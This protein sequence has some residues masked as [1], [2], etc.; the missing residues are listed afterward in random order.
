MKLKVITFW[1]LLLGPSTELRELT[2]QMMPRLIMHQAR[3]NLFNGHP[4]IR[5]SF[6]PVRAIPLLCDSLVS[7]LSYGEVC[8]FPASCAIGLPFRRYAECESKIGVTTCCD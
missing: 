8:I 6:Y 1:R 2:A 4:F 5:R 7:S 3:L